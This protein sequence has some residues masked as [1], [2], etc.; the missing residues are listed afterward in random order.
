MTLTGRT[1]P[2]RGD[3]T[4]AG[5]ESPRSCP[6][7]NFSPPP[8]ASF[9]R[10]RRGGEQYRQSTT[11]GFRPRPRCCR[12]SGSIHTRLTHHPTDQHPLNQPTQ[13]THTTNPHNQPTQPTHTTNPHNQPTQLD[14]L[15]AAVHRPPPDS[16]TRPHP[17]HTDESTH[18]RRRNNGAPNDGFE[19]HEPEP[20][21]SRPTAEPPP[22]A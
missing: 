7:R 9:A 8:A 21:T 19:P 18:I 2:D 10:G 3:S 1:S 15:I 17:G 22:R 12:P 4:V 13:P 6:P 14:H 20:R 11:G 5:G 16:Q